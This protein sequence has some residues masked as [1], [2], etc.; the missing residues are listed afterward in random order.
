VNCGDTF[1]A[2]RYGFMERESIPNFYISY[3]LNILNVTQVSVE[4]RHG[5]VIVIG[6]TT[7]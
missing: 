4:S 3:L 5:N 6:P 2:V 1:F 7:D